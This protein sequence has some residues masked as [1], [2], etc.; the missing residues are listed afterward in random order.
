[1]ERDLRHPLARRHV[2]TVTTFEPEPPRS[3]PSRSLAPVPRTVGSGI[4]TDG[5]PQQRR[6]QRS[7]R[8]V[9]LTGQPVP[10]LYSAHTLSDRQP[11]PMQESSRSR[12]ASLAAIFSFSRSRQSREMP[13]Q[14]AGVGARFAGRRASSLLTSSRVS[15]TL[16]AA[17][18]KANRRN[19]IHSY[20]RWLPLVRPAVIR[21]SRS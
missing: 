2:L 9:G 8:G 21:P 10:G 19:T 6:Q 18:M 20:R 14:S 17:R 16:R 4:A 12:R 7:T 1:M 3:S 15:P 11:Q 13:R 5:L